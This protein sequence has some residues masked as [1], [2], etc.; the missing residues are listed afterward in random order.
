MKK[1]VLIALLLISTL[2]VACSSTP[3]P[4][5]PTPT[6]NG[7]RLTTNPSAVTSSMPINRRAYNQ[8][9]VCVSL[10]VVDSAGTFT[11][12][13]SGTHFPAGNWGVDY[14]LTDEHGFNAMFHLSE[15]LTGT[16]QVCFNQMTNVRGTQYL[17]V[18]MKA[19]TLNNETLSKLSITVAVKK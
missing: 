5:A 10:G 14:D 2:F 8:D 7:Y 12:L 17:T 15:K 18:T 3:A 1:F 16:L 11:A 4:V 9:W 13:E 6:Q 19:V